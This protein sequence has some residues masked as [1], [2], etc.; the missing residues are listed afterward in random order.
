MDDLFTSLY[1]SMVQPLNS[2]PTIAGAPPASS[3][4]SDNSGFSLTN[5]TSGLGNIFST[6]INAYRSYTGA[7][8]GGSSA[9]PARASSSQSSWSQYLPWILIGGGVLVVFLIFRRK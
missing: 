5:L 2:G 6:G 1:G 9:T 7:T 8:S 3:A 4:P